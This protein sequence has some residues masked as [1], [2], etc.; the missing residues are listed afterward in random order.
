MLTEQEKNEWERIYQVGKSKETIEKYFKELID[1]ITKVRNL[2]SENN[3][4]PSKSLSFHLVIEDQV[5]FD[6]FTQ[7]KHFFTKFL[8]AKHLKIEQ[9]FSSH[10]EAIL[11]IG[12][13]VQTYVIKTGLI[14][15][16][17]EKEALFKQKEQLE[18]EI[19]RSKALLSNPNFTSKAPEQK[20]NL[21]KEKYETY[22]KQYEIVVEKLKT[23]V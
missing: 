15:P 21:E 4:I 12:A 1:V 8:N 3:V 13:K 11:L 5:W 10:E 9:S 2:R 16:E 18:A 22:Q 6:I 17:K 20:L 23:Y 19:M 14:D 7:Q